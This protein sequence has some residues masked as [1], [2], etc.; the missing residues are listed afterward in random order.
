MSWRVIYRPGMRAY[1]LPFSAGL[2]LTVSAFL[3]WVTLG[4]DSVAGFPD[5]A[6]LWVAGLGL[7]A[8]ILAM[9]S[10]ITRKNSRHPLLLVGLAGLGITLLSWRIVPRTV[11]NRVLI[12]SQA[13]AIVEHRPVSDLPKASA[14]VGIYLGL[15]ASSLITAFGLTIIVKRA[16]AAYAVT[17]P[18]DDV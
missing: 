5:A 10:L 14:G 17:D 15:V 4:N 2:M 7:I 16:S 9:L 18:N 1:W 12:R 11:E 3:P 13:E 8:A 6:G